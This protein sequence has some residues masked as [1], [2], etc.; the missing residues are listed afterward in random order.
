MSM[1]KS[2]LIEE[3]ADVRGLPR[4]QAEDVVNTLLSA[5][6][7]SLASGNRIEVRG[8]GSFSLKQHRAYVGRNP[9]T[10]EEVGVPAK[11]SIHFKVGKELRESVEALTD[12]QQEKAAAE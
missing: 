4:N 10:G 9:R 11:H 6:G 8:T 5:I 2:E 3:L 12:N 1:T 7:D